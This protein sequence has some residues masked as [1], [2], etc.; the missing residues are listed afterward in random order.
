MNVFALI[1]RIFKERFCYALILFTF[2]CF[3]VE[4][5]S[6][7]ESV[8]EPNAGSNGKS[9]SKLRMLF[10][11][12]EMY[13]F[14]QTGGLGSV[15]SPITETLS[16][17]GVE[18]VV[19]MPLWSLISDD[20]FSI[21]KT[22]VKIRVPMPWGEK[23]PNGDTYLEAELY[24]KYTKGN[25]KVIFVGE[26]KNETFFTLS[27][28]SKKIYDE[29]DEEKAKHRNLTRFSFFSKAVLEVA[30]LYGDN[31][32]DVIHA[33]DWTT[34]LVPW[35]KKYWSRYSGI[36][37]KTV[38]TIHNLRYQGSYSPDILWLL[39]IEPKFL[40]P[41]IDG[42]VYNYG[43]INLTKAALSSSDLVS[44]VSPEYA[45]DIKTEKY[46]EYLN[47]I[48][49]MLEI[50]GIKH[51]TDLSRYDP[52]K[53]S[54]KYNFGKD[55]FTEQKKE[56]KSY[57]QEKL[58]LPV[59]DVPLFIN[60]TRGDS[61]KNVELLYETLKRVLPMMDIQVVIIGDDYNKLYYEGESL[62]SKFDRLMKQNPNKLYFARFNSLLQVELE[63]A[64][65][66][67]FIISAF[68]PG[69]IEPN[70]AK[71][72]RVVSIVHPV[73]GLENAIVGQNDPQGRAQT[74]IIVE[75]LDFWN[76]KNQSIEK[77][78]TA[79]LYAIE[80]Y[81]D[82][83]LLRSIRDNMD[84]NYSWRPSI[85]EYIEMYQKLV[86]SAPKPPVSQ[87]QLKPSEKLF[88]IPLPEAGYNN[89]K[90]ALELFLEY[91]YGFADP[92]L[93]TT[94]Y[95][96]SSKTYKGKAYSN[97]NGLVIVIQATSSAKIKFGLNDLPEELIT[98]TK[99]EYRKGKTPF[100]LFNIGNRIGTNGQLIKN[101]GAKNI[102][103]GKVA[104]ITLLKGDETWAV[105]KMLYNTLPQ[106]EKY[107]ILGGGDL[108]PFFEEF[109]KK[110][111][112]REILLAYTGI[113][114][115][116]DTYL[117]IKTLEKIE[118]DFD[119][120]NNELS[121]FTLMMIGNSLVMDYMEEVGVY[122]ANIIKYGDGISSCVRL[123]RS[124]M[125]IAK[126]E[127]PGTGISYHNPLYYKDIKAIQELRTKMRYL[128]RP[129]KK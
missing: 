34:A 119:A 98:Q 92:S 7:D 84:G 45:R 52:E 95:S 85:K 44:T 14:V 63:A 21:Q 35:Y 117:V 29:T 82:K 54:A 41:M 16:V 1:N 5:S 42:S 79:I 22:G 64:A 39:Q 94:V 69:G 15:S 103:D 74:G 17:E 33:N 101:A 24:E 124:T 12:P 121:A 109:N 113:K 127:G 50:V 70:I 100:E 76:N 46:G 83:V 128:T 90:D 31:Y 13:P 88:S 110:M 114:S 104:V 66:F 9:V 97:S 67:Q 68:E 26:P 4:L 37:A 102:F 96:L 116:T 11:T 108:N 89:R 30:K 107:R 91:K 48:L 86:L 6:Q 10:A 57:V 106:A 118:L 27:S 126:I 122:P 58:L 59:R 3:S 2:I 105:E 71:L 38:Y 55:D 49:S 65:D 20:N 72:N 75:D 19:V 47:G 112:A 53:N 56:N 129:G 62:S 51:G 78:E 99:E 93:Q 120:N 73:N 77:L 8:P 125:G 25:V 28:G 87:Y 36:K 115:A 61:Q 18:V 32:F 80:I 23:D 40:D 111:A 43:S 123:L 60:T 81:S